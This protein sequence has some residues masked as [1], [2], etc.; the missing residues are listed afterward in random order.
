MSLSIV[1]SQEMRQFSLHALSLEC[2]VLRAV[3][4]M[5]SCDAETIIEAGERVLYH[6]LHVSVCGHEGCVVFFPVGKS[7]RSNC[8]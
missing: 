6:P 1:L 8:S 5:K 7:S 2:K 4:G 3:K